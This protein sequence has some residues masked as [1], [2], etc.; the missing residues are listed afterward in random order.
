MDEP[1]KDAE[2]RTLG[3][4]RTTP[5]GR[6]EAYD[7]DRRYKGYFD[8]RNGLTKDTGGATVTKGNTV[9]GLIFSRR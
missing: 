6:Q 9:G 8:Q 5:S 7:A 2:G 4:I 3:F 1:I